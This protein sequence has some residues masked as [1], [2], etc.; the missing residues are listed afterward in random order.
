MAFIL[1]VTLTMLIGW[2][3]PP[4]EVVLTNKAKVYKEC[5]DNQT[6]ACA[7]LRINQFKEEVK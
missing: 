2:I 3:A 4:M 7:R 1:G 5:Q 6:H